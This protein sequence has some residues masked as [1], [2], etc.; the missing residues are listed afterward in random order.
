MDPGKYAFQRHSRRCSVPP[1]RA[2]EAWTDAGQIK[3]WL[4]E[5]G[6]DVSSVDLDL[7]IGEAFNVIVQIA[8]GHVRY[9]GQFRQINRPRRLVFVLA[10]MRNPQRASQVTVD[11]EWTGAPDC[12]QITVR[13]TT[14]LRDERSSNDL[15]A[16]WDTLL[17]GLVRM[18]EMPG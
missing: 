11:F 4:D 7:R 12:C 14:P 1:E 5:C 8:T 17:D 2:F 6:C 15:P 13:A 18:F 16:Y 3:Q 9:C 10:D